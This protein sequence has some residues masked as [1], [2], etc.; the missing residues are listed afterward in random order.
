[1]LLVIWPRE[2]LAKDA[3]VDAPGSGFRSIALAHNEPSREGVDQ[4]F[5]EAL[6]A[7]ATATQPPRDTE[8]GG[9]AGYFADPDGH[10]WEIAYNPFTD[11]T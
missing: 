5:A 3:A 8:W 11:L 4:V 7:G 6:A 1:M 2:E 9:Y 10:L